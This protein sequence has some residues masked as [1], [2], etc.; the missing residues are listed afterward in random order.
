IERALLDDLIQECRE[1]RAEL[2]AH[3]HLRGIGRATH[4]HVKAAVAHLGFTLRLVANWLAF[5][6]EAK[7]L[8]RRRQRIGQA[9]DPTDLGHLAGAARSAAWSS[10][11]SAS[12]SRVREPSRRTTAAPG[13]AC[14][15]PST[16]VGTS[17]QY[18]RGPPRR[19]S[20][21]VPLATMRPLWMMPTWS[22]SRSTIS[23]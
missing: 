1:R 16:A 9:L 7:R 17:I 12:S 5:D 18:R 13:T 22:Q 21:T 8:H 6:A 11:P 23:S 2:V 3:E 10:V 4:Q 20:S 15:Q 19:S 14:A